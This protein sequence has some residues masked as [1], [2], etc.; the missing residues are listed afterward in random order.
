[1]K[2]GLTGSLVPLP[3][4]GD[5]RSSCAWWTRGISDDRGTVGRPAM[6]DDVE[7]LA[8]FV[9]HPFA[10]ALLRREERP[11]LHEML[12]ALEEVGMV[13]AHRPWRARRT[14]SQSAGPRLRWSGPRD[15]RASEALRNASRRRFRRTSGWKRAGTSSS[16]QERGDLAS[17]RPDREG[18]SRA[19]PHARTAARMKPQG[20]LEETPI[21]MGQPSFGKVS[22]ACPR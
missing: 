5:P 18:T 3:T 8:P 13:A 12:R 6:A 1:M 16:V 4:P 21:G 10:S 2:L 15:L 14:R 7:P 22:S 17:R 19:L 20:R 11:A 9:I